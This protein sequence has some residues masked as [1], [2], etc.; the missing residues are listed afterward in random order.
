M[1]LKTSLRKRYKKIH[2]AHPDED[3][4]G[5]IPLDDEIK[6]NTFYVVKN[7]SIKKDITVSFAKYFSLHSNSDK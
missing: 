4:Y 7:K 6:I 3:H 2:F 5:R 1:K